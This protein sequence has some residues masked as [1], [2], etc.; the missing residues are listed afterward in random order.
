MLLGGKILPYR[1]IGPF[2]CSGWRL[3]ARR[4][5]ASCCLWL[6]VAAPRGDRLGDGGRCCVRG[7]AGGGR[8]CL[9]VN[10]ALLLLPLCR[11]AE[12]VVSRSLEGRC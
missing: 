5:S 8:S 3:V 10:Q 6:L 4:A 7:T 1:L 2:F 12:R 9:I 11:C